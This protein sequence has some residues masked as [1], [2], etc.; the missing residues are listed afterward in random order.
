VIFRESWILDGLPF[1]VVVNMLISFIVFDLL[2]LLYIVDRM[3]TCHGLIALTPDINFFQVLPLHIMSC[4]RDCF[5]SRGSE[6]FEIL[7]QTLFISLY[8]PPMPGTLKY[9]LLFSTK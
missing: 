5:L 9:M 7:L 8:Q 1:S 2:L 4:L 6:F 3:P